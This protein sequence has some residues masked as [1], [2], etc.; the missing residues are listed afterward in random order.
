MLDDEVLEREPPRFAVLFLAVLRLAVLR[1]AVLRLAVL[2]FAVVRLVA[3]R[4]APPR[5][6]APFAALRFAPPRLVALFLAPPRFAV[7]FLPPERLLI[8]GPRRVLF[9][10]A[11]RFVPRPDFFVAIAASPRRK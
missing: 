5:F 8:A 6:D 3:L 7:L 4:L 9:F 1:L 2:R 10:P 11:L